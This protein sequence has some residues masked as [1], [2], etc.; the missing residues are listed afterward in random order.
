[1]PGVRRTITDHGLRFTRAMVSVSLC[2]PSRTSIL[3]GQY[4][5]NTGVLT[6]GGPTA[7]SRPCTGTATNARRSRRGS[8]RAGYQT[9][10][11]GKYLNGFPNTAGLHYVPPG[12]TDFVSPVVGQ[13]YTQFDY[14]LSVNGRLEHHG[15]RPS[16]YGTD[17]YLR[18]AERFIAH[19]D[20]GATRRSSSTSP[21]TRRTGRPL[22]HR[23]TPTCSTASACHAIPCS[24]RRRAPTE[25]RWLQR[26]PPMTPWE[27]A[28]SRALFDRRRE[29][30][31]AVD[32]AVVVLVDQ[33]EGV[34]RAGP[35]LRGVQQRQRFHQGQYRLP[36]GSRPSSTPTSGSRSSPAVRRSRCDGRRARSSA[37]S[38]SHRR[39]RVSP[40]PGYRVLSTA[41][42]SRGAHRAR[43]AVS[44]TRVPDRALGGAGGHPTVAAVAAR[45]RGPRPA[46]DS[47]AAVVAPGAGSGGDGPDWEGSGEEGSGGEGSAG[48]HRPRHDPRVPRR[49]HRHVHLCGVSRR[50]ARA[51]RPASRPYELRNV[52]GAVTRETQIA[53]GEEARSAGGL[54]RA[55]S[56]AWTTRC[57]PVEIRYR[58]RPPGTPR[59]G[60]SARTVKPIRS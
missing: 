20:R 19:A 51:L 29:S 8:G 28:R 16:D 48:H 46:G 9:A 25:P 15:H 23:V 1:M 34:A 14:T 42:R 5:D 50:R 26:V 55:G 33:L 37:T 60:S 49:A 22:R 52:Y 32:R 53:L 21:C 35:D 11:I 12:W 2:C 47:V 56:A 30:L 6:N 18:H 31:R 38:T 44:P 40:A 4:A 36:A 7:G 24:T 41:T 45:T 17:V 43:A 59:P 3:R 57:P 39:S 27:I 54:P 10:L 13:P 58:G